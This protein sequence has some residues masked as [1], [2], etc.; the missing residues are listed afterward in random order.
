[1][2]ITLSHRM[3]ACDGGLFHNLQKLE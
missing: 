3:S 2:S 1:M